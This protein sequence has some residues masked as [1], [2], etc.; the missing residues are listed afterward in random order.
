MTSFH[1]FDSESSPGRREPRRSTSFDLLDERVRRWVWDAGWQQLRDI[2]EAAV[3]SI[4]QERSDLIIAAAT[5]AGKTEAAFLP[6]CSALVGGKEKTGI[7]AL[8]VSPLKALIN[9]QFR[10]LEDLCVALEIPV[11]RWHGDVP[12]SRKRKVVKSPSG[13]LLITPESLEAL[14]VI[15]GHHMGSLFSSLDWVVIDELHAFI[16]TD[17]GR[18][19]QS[20]LHRL[21]LRAAHRVPRVGLSATL[22]D[23]SLAAEFLRPGADRSIE[24]IVSSAAGQEV[25]LQI[26]GYVAPTHS[27]KG[28]PRESE[29]VP[30]PTV[31]EK[32][33]AHLF[34]TLRGKDHLV[35]ANS[36][37]KVEQYADLLRR[38]SE[39]ERLPNEFFPHHGN[40]S[41][42]IRE[43][44]EAR[45][46]DPT[47][48]TTAICTST[49]ELGIDIGQVASIGQL[50]PPFS[51]SSLRQRLG[52]SGRRG[53]PAVLRFYIHEPEITVASHLL[54]RLRVGLIQAVA[55]V[56]LL[57]ERWCEPPTAGALHLSVLVQQVLSMIAERGGVTARQAWRTL[58]V[59]G[60]FPSVDP[61]RFASLL[62][63]MGHEE[64]L[65]QTEDGTL[66][67]GEKGERLVNHFTF[68]A[69]FQ[70]PEEYQVLHRG[71]PLGTLTFDYLLARGLH[72]IFAGRRW[73]VVSVEADQKQVSV[74]P[75]PGGKVPTFVGSSG[76]PIHDRIRIKMREVWEG[77]GLPRYLNPCAVRLLTEARANY[78][79]LGLDARRLVAL[80]DDTIFFFCRGDT[81]MNT[82]ALQLLRRRLKVT[83][84]GPALLIG[85]A[86][87]A[88]VRSVLTELV[89][90][91]VADPA[92]L[93]A[94]A[95]NQRSGKYDWVLGEE[96]QE[97]D[98]SSRAIN[99]SE[100]YLALRDA[101]YPRRPEI[102]RSE[103]TEETVER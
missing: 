91:G 94:S 68:Y 42:E 31:E 28:E 65:V 62:R 63:S 56:E 18:Q 16:G 74:E 66:L 23:L 77:G 50:G 47:T 101:S 37:H 45:L 85:E 22:G 20:L 8:Y 96:L 40:L 17:R 10:R 52:R 95:A 3:R 76:G 69:I 41:R 61:T 1:P 75:S 36:R 33:S 98:Y 71:R 58:C 29:T 92:D 78:A 34:N 80:G 89:Q 44:V 5:A 27:T 48:P 49:L 51:V 86:R 26:R 72:I 81:I 6:I 39:R 70:T 67:L 38:R 87:P 103:M 93:A 19:L 102:S 79:R 25:R 60:P 46:K 83:L 84:E 9:D 88:E 35:F 43:G 90:E 15:H 11:H 54:D 7:R 82:V 13:I 59:T 21:E 97:A 30:G 2:Q 64:L 24:T 53:E 4:L 14:F 32:I 73:R 99:T 12:S 57:I 100:A 55:M